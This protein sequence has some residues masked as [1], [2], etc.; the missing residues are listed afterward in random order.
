MN[1]LDLKLRELIASVQQL[2]PNSLERQ[3][4]LAQM[5]LLVMKSG[6]LWK[7]HTSYY[8]DALQEMWE[9]CCEHPEE[10]NSE[11]KSPIVW[12]DDELKKRLRR[13]RDGKNRQQRRFL[14]TI[15]T[16]QGIISNPVDG[17]VSPP[18]IHSVMEMWEKTIS[19]VE[20]DSEQRLRNIC[21][22]KRPEIN[23]Q[24]LILRRLPPDTPSWQT[25]ALEFKLNPQ[26]AKDLPKF[27]NRKC[28]PLLREF[29]L[30]QGYI[31]ESDIVCSGTKQT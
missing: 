1:Q 21:F 31:E 6:K 28:L 30:S 20:N 18:D 23:A 12:L 26:E 13:M 10:Y 29:G 25:I 9:Y 24:T 8:N 7:E 5:Y 27:Y 2:P 11:I 15:Q 16:E 17:I 4:I 14:T 19:W 3:Q 22:R